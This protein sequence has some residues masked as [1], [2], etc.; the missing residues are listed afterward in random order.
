MRPAIALICLVVLAAT[1]WL[2][3][4]SVAQNAARTEAELRQLRGEIAKIT[5]RMA[6]DAAERDRLTK[7]LRS[8]EKSAATVRREV[9]RLRDER[10]QRE[11]ERASLA[12]DRERRRL[13]LKAERERLADQLRA[14]HRQG[15]DQALKIFLAQDEPGRASRLFAYFGYLGRAQAEQV[16]TIEVRERGFPLG[17]SGPR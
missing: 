14:A 7:E 17:R 5:A 12:A 1:T 8:T 15:R 4:E 10:G 13:Q 16:A 11:R 3:P 6:E 2:V 9:N